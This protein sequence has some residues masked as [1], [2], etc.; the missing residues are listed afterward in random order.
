M[1]QAFRLPAAPDFA[2][3]V[4][5]VTGDELDASLVNLGDFKSTP[6]I[7]DALKGYIAISRVSGLEDL[8]IL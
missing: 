2:S 4:H 6:Q 1:D 8:R 5:A 7:E 3:T